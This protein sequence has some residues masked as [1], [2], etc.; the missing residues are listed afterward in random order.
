M[1]R[2][3][4][5]SL[6]I[7]GALAFACG[8]RA[9]TDASTALRTVYQQA[10]GRVVPVAAA[11]RAAPADSANHQETLTTK[12]TVLAHPTEVR[13]SF[14]VKNDIGKQVEV[15]FP[16]GHAYDFIVVDAA[17]KEVWRW[18]RERLFTQ[19][20]QNRL[21]SKGEAIRISER[22]AKPAIGTY[23]AIATLKSS[24]YPVEQRVSFT[25]Q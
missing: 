25:L 10:Q 16:S 7:F 11:E 14:E 5:I 12:F 17:G 4:L 24:N 2:R 6:C 13:F 19:L 20:V 21:L 23:T 15:T 8:P 9:N 22:W 1:D 18:G 3:V